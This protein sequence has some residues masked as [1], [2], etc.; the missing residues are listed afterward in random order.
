MERDNALQAEGVPEVFEGWGAPA[1]GH[2][3]W[4]IPKKLYRV[5]NCATVENIIENQIMIFGI[6]W[7]MAERS[8]LGKLGDALEK[9]M[10]AFRA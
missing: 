10:N 4:N 1:Y 6:Q 3:L 9:V 2:H 7:L 8:Q 5:E